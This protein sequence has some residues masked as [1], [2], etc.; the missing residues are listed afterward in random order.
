MNFILQQTVKRNVSVSG[1]ISRV[2]H[3][4]ECFDPL[5][6]DSPLFSLLLIIVFGALNVM[7]VLPGAQKVALFYNMQTQ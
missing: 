5:L 4:L 3:V 6:L 7:S 1:E 2:L